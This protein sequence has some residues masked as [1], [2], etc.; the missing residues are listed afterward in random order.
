LEDSA[1]NVADD[2]E[3]VPDVVSTV[4]NGG[5][6]N[7]N[8]IGCIF[9]LRIDEPTRYADEGNS[10]WPDNEAVKITA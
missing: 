10:K 1:E 4:C 7:E 2:E 8:V 3:K 6:G 5:P 9:F